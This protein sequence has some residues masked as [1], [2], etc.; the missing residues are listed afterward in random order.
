M[1]RMRVNYP[2]PLQRHHTM[3]HRE[4]IRDFTVI[5]DVEDNQIGLLAGFE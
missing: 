3:I 1:L 5:V 4:V 2:P